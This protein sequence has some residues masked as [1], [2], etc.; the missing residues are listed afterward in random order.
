MLSL[1]CS[2]SSCNGA[3]PRDLIGDVF[4]TVVNLFCSV[5]CLY[6]DHLCDDILSLTTQCIHLNIL[7]AMFSSPNC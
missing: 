6:N 5:K 3:V 2:D 7:T 4:V 1:Q